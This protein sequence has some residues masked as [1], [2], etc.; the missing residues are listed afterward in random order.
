MLE[1]LIR[2]DLFNFGEMGEPLAGM[3]MI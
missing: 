3:A 1:T 2:D